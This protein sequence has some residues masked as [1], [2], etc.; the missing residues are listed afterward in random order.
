MNLVKAS[1]GVE[2]VLE[3][4]AVAGV[5]ARKRSWTTSMRAG[6]SV[7]VSNVDFYT[8]C[9]ATRG[10]TRYRAHVTL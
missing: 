8:A 1:G 3:S 5:A 6:K 4:L 9:F 7:R 2:C 10:A